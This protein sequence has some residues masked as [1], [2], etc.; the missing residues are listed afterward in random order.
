[1]TG[2]ERER[3]TKRRGKMDRKEGGVRKQMKEMTEGGRE[4]MQGR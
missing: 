4:C 2:V 1:M 3:E